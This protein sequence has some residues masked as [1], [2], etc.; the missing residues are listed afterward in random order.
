MP[1]FREE[2]DINQKGK[3]EQREIKKLRPREQVD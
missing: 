2:K 1:N 3:Q